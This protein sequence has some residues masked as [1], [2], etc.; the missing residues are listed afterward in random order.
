M[1]KEEFLNYYNQEL[2]YLRHSG[3][4]FAERYPKVAGQL[5]ITEDTSK[6]PHIERLLE[7]FAF[8][9]AKLNY[10]IDQNFL[11]MGTELLNNL[12]PHFTKPIPS[13][14]IA[15]FDLTANKMSMI[16]KGTKL[17]AFPEG[18]GKSQRITFKT[19]YDVNIYP[20]N[21]TQTKLVK[22]P[23]YTNLPDQNFLCFQFKG[24]NFETID[25]I[26]FHIKSPKSKAFMIYQALF[27]EDNPTIY[28]SLDGKNVTPMGKNILQPLGF[29]RHEAMLPVP[30]HASHAYYLMQ[31]FFHYIEK[32]LFFKLQLKNKIPHSSGTLEIFIPVDTHHIPQNISHN[33][34]NTKSVPIINLFEATTDPIRMDHKKLEY[35]LIV[36]QHNPE[37]FE[38]YDI[39]TVYQVIPK[40]GTK[41]IQPF[42]SYQHHENPSNIFWA[43]N[44]KESKLRNATGSDIHLNFLYEDYSL[45]KE[46]ITIYAK[47]LATNRNLVEN[48][49]EKDSLFSETISSARDIK[50]SK[51]PKYFPYRS[52]LGKNLWKL[53]AQLSINHMSFADKK[54]SLNIL[55]EIIALNTDEQEPQIMEALKEISSNTIAK[56]VQVGNFHGYLRGIEVTLS[57][58]NIKSDANPIFIFCAILR[59]FFAMSIT[60]NSFITLKIIDHETKKEIKTWPPLLGKQKIL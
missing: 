19:I 50:V 38:I 27:Q 58:E 57:I 31:E 30:Q 44:R 16:P 2:A 46:N 59:Q 14:S 49:N 3:S 51:K 10:K 18:K 52:Q 55:K 33:D 53:L 25:N 5:N 24:K 26:T 60:V 32:F 39:K 48:I 7:S 28:Y 35:P 54:N 56:R 4:K 13:F 42:F 43:C 21:L 17:S 23:E 15:E 45:I 47:V 29:Q 20:I 34:F 11:K 8:L 41:P 22:K 9:T 37:A 36:N 1:K 40:G 6:D 12:Y